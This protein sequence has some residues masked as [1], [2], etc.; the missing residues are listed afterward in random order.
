MRIIAHR[1]ACARAP[2]NTLAAFRL[3]LRAG[4]GMIELDVHLTAD[5]IPVVIHDATLSRTT[6]GE[7]RVAERTL[8]DLR[9]LSAGAWF[10]ERFRNERVPSLEEVFRLVGRRAE[11][12]VEIKGEAEAVAQTAG[13]ALAIARESGALD[14]TLFS[15]FD[16]DA[17]VHC[18][19][20][21]AR[22]RL[23][24][25]TGWTTLASPGAADPADVDERVRARHSA[26]GHLA[27]EAANLHRALAS[28]SLVRALHGDGYAVYL[29]KV[30][31]PSAVQAFER[32][33]VDGVFADDP[34]PLLA[35]WPTDAAR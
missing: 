2:E 16:P 29:Y 33:G 8:A 6:D 24:L 22:A 27:L 17:L 20:E 19:R 5:G 34:V 3:A 14:R 35:R 4:V 23:A 26:W 12:N 28:P 15:S 32:M 1:G 25:L 7:G 30:D 21:S 13:A 11:I 31:E 18:R 10:D 9:G